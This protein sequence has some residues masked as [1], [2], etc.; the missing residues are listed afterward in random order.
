[1]L[2]NFKKRLPQRS[3]LHINSFPAVHFR[4]LDGV[5]LLLKFSN[6]ITIFSIALAVA[7]CNLYFFT[8]DTKNKYSD[9]S[10]A[11]KFLNYHSDLNPLLYTKNASTITTI[12]RQAGFISQAQAEN[13]EGLN[14]EYFSGEE[15]QSDF[16]IESDTLLSQA[17]DSVD[18]LISKQIKV[19]Q[20]KAGDNLQKISKA[21]G[22]SENTIIWANKLPSIAI[23][24]GWYLLILPTDGILHTAS[25]NDTLPDIAKKYSGNLERIISYN[26]L[27]NAEDIDGG[28]LII[29]PDGKMPEAPK[30]KVV[31][32]KIV[33]GKVKPQG[34][35]TPRIVDNGTGHIFP[36]GYCTWYVATK[37]HVPWGGNAKNWLANA[38]AYGA[39]ITNTASVGSIVVTT[40]NTRYGHVALVESVDEK[41]FTVSEMNY[42]KFG[43]VNTRFISH[44]SKIIR[45]FILP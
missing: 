12:N 11:A 24:P 2:F 37:V 25:T 1:M 19:Y 27:E 3:K 4:K 40:D 33:D 34:V 39:V 17:P 42:S 44:S 38:K 7:L 13:F 45:G 43:K 36:W 8:G 30:P 10:L 31:I 23:K 41:G 14:V 18:T 20:T 26:G 15:S 6:E 35:T 28:Q 16:S 32:P 9:N 5:D 22:I 21:H 29:I